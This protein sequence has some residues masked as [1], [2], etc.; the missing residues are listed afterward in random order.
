MSAGDVEELA[1]RLSDRDLAILHSVAE[2]YFL[3]ARQVEVLHFPDHGPASGPRIARRTLARLRDLRLLGALERHIGGYGRGSEGF[4]HHVDIVGDQLISARSGR[5][6]R[7]F[8]EPSR[9]FVRHKLAIVNT[10]LALIQADREQR[11]E[12]VD[13]TVEPASWRRFTGLGGA[14]LTLKPDLYAE[15]AASPGSEL[16]RAWFVEVDLGTE[17]IVTLLK[18]CGDYE[19]YR[20]TG[21][22]QAHG[23]GFPVVVW[24]VT[25]ADAAKAERRRQ[26]LREAIDRDR[27]L[28]SALFR[29]VAPDQLVPLLANGGEA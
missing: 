26:A 6:A 4:V 17:G 11:L 5:K 2:H 3:T 8:H 25:H 14:R 18:K 27:S 21:L 23:G 7:R 22:E 29:I 15:T 13:S 12:L 20:R 19:T 1:A 9:R 24:S 10:R 28:P 16:V